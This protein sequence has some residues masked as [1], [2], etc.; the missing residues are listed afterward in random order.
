MN[1]LA[2]LVLCLPACIIES[3]SPGPVD[4]SCVGDLPVEIDTGA[5]ITHTAGVDAGYYLEY[6]G[7]G[8]WHIEWTCDTKLSALG[9][10][11]SGTI[12]VPGT[13]NATC[14]QCEPEDVLTTSNTNTDTVIQFNTGTSTGI[15]GVDITGGSTSSRTV[16]FDLLIN[17]IYQPDL[18]YIPAH[19]QT[20]SP[21]CLPIAATPSTP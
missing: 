1:R 15:D 10:E 18:V 19:G 16:R 2:L 7:N 13:A 11:F 8:A 17:G 3:S 6:D 14:Y 20:D 21:S 9:C 12:T 5:S 4:T